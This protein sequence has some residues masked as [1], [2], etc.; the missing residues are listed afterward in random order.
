[1][2][3]GAKAAKAVHSEHNKN[4]DSSSSSD[5]EEHTSPT[6]IK[7]KRD[8]MCRKYL[9]G[10]FPMPGD[11]EF[12]YDKRNRSWRGLCKQSNPPYV[13]G[14]N[15]VVGGE[16]F[17]DHEGRQPP[18]FF[19][20]VFSRRRRVALDVTV[21][22]VTSPACRWGGRGRKLLGRGKVGVGN[23]WVGNFLLTEQFYKGNGVHM[24]PAPSPLH[25]R[26]SLTVPPVITH[27]I[28]RVI[29]QFTI[30]SYICATADCGKT[31]HL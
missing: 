30:I 17:P 12:S 10:F 2:K 28:I 18:S 23:C 26:A 21:V 25:P 31:I 13:R 8:D 19:F 5:S 16:C 1:M 3:E 29:I 4:P 7:A 20:F 6:L 24:G 15:A 27:F 11:H 14:S 9:G 22:A